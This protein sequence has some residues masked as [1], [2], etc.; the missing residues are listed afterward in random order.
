[1]LNLSAAPA[2]VVTIPQLLGKR[3]K[4]AVIT[5]SSLGLES[6]DSRL[7]GVDGGEA[8]R[9]WIVCGQEPRA[10]R[11]VSLRRE[12]NYYVTLTV[13]PRGQCS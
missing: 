9:G 4:A 10:G 11:R 1:M 2:C 7:I 12:R 8:E 13:A 3:L 6:M 5:L